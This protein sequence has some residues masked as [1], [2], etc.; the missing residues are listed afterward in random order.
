MLKFKLVR[1]AQVVTK[2]EVSYSMTLFSDNG[3][4]C[5]I[6]GLTKEQASQFNEE[7]II[8]IGREASIGNNA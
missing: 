3:G 5:W 8:L 7:D 1:I 4:M 6:E 2:N